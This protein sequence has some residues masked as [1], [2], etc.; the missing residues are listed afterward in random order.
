MNEYAFFISR[1]PEDGLRAFVKQ[2]RIKHPIGPMPVDKMP[3]ALL[4]SSMKQIFE[5]GLA[6]K[7]GKSRINFYEKLNNIGKSTMNNY[8][9]PEAKG[10][11]LI[12]ICV[13]NLHIPEPYLI[14]YIFA[15]DIELYKELMEKWV[16]NPPINN[17]FDEYAKDI[18]Q[19]EYI[20]IVFNQTKILN[21]DEIKSLA[22]NIVNNEDK[23]FS[24]KIFDFS[25]IHD[26]HI[27]NLSEQL[28]NTE[29][30][31]PLLYPFVL[32]ILFK[33]LEN[34]QHQKTNLATKHK[35]ASEELTSLT[36]K[37]S[38]SSTK[39]E[40]LTQK[41][42]N[43]TR[44]IQNLIKDI[45]LINKHVKKLELSNQ[46][47]TNIILDKG[48]Q[49][50][51]LN[52]QIKQLDND[53]ETIQ[54]QNS[55]LKLQISHILE[56]F[57]FKHVNMVVEK[58]TELKNQNDVF[59]AMLPNPNDYIIVTNSYFKTIVPPLIPIKNI[60][61]ISTFTEK[62]VF[63]NYSGKI[64]YLHRQSFGTTIEYEDFKEEAECWSR[65]EEIVA[66]SEQEWIKEL[67]RK[68]VE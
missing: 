6:Q 36:S 39:I 64:I 17:I 11:E 40:Q 7:K 30:D 47:K 29:P 23:P 28:I 15:N 5:D 19:E 27:K 12:K 3:Y 31:N 55:E 65:V 51:N 46:E 56:R 8:K 25:S 14:A 53:N 41:N 50:S 32:W 20:K 33:E 21:A 54:I 24:D 57:G 9:L 16:D 45:D 58:I 13:M 37:L 48:E 26:E 2:L 49:V 59:L 34:I 18:P 4:K 60:I 42:E 44:D 1:F 10:K 61:E 68:G 43:L 63:S 22:Q 66:F 62:N 52:E 38:K 67:I 35:K